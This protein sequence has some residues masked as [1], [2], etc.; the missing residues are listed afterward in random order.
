MSAARPK[1]TG[2]SWLLL[3]AVGL[4]LPCAAILIIRA[5]TRNLGSGDSQHYRYMAEHPFSLTAP[6]FGYR[7]LVPYFA[8]LIH[9]LSPLTLDQSFFALSCL[10]F[11]L[12][13]FTIVVWSCKLLHSSLLTSALLSILYSFSYGGVYNLHNYT[14]VGFGE[15]LVLLLGFIAILHDR[16]DWLLPV[17]ASGSL[18]KETTALLI[19]VYGAVALG[20][21]THPRQ[22]LKRTVTLAGVFL[23]IF[24]MLRTGLL[25]IDRPI[26]NRDPSL[27]GWSLFRFV[28]EYY[29]GFQGAFKQTL[30]AF[31]IL[32]P[33][34]FL[35]YKEADRVSR[36]AC[37]LIPLTLLQ[38]LVATDITR[39][40]SVAF[41][42]I[43]LLLNCLY[44]TITRAEAVVLTCSS[45]LVFYLYDFGFRT[46]TTIVLSL[47]YGLIGIWYIATL[48]HRPRWDRALKT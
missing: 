13:N 10:F 29:G 23:S 43:L 38:I 32:W 8:A 21:R 5:T 26:L 6:P 1:R 41:P 17:L 4:L 27:I 19:P 15:H 31:P 20:R 40:A 47:S 48:R 45:V 36:A 3:C 44:R 9:R 16:F 11:V 34:A 39:M 14:H 2:Q 42:A 35:G 37:I 46:L 28:Y 12:I 7:V 22:V 18:V 30:A 25:F 24:L 33:L